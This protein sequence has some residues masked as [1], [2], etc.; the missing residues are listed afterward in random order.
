VEERRSQ[1]EQATADREAAEALGWRERRKM[2]PRASECE[3]LLKERLAEVRAEL[4]GMEPPSSEARQEHEIARQ[5]LATRSAQALAAARIEPPAY[6]V[7][8]LGERPADPA[9]AKAWDRGVQGIEGYRLEH[10]VKDQLSA[11]GRDPQ[12]AIE[13]AA[14]KAAQ[15]SLA[16]TQHGLGLE[17]RQAQTRQRGMGIER[18][19]GIGR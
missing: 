4:A 15:R 19:L 18:S 16:Q 14:R 17:R 13:R 2:M 9:K 10:G 1:V 6:I 8:E 7:K 5:L 3:R 12:S 11:F